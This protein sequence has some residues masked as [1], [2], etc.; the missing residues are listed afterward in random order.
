MEPTKETKPEHST[1][2][3]PPAQLKESGN[4]ALKKGDTDG[5]VALYTAAITGCQ[6]E[7]SEKSSGGGADTELLAVCLTNRGVARMGRKPKMLSDDLSLAVA[8]FTKA[9][10]V[11]LHSRLPSRLVAFSSRCLRSQHFF[12]HIL[13]H[14]LLMLSS[15]P[16]QLSLASIQHNS[17]LFP[18]RFPSHFPHVL[19][20]AGSS[21]VLQGALPPRNGPAE[22]E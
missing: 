8:D 1:G 13:H 4:T 22:A 17:S 6:A 19:R 21:G 2:A 15:F 20:D 9:T 18:S 14:A 3:A 16:P 12:S 5:A 7:G 10:Q 11:R